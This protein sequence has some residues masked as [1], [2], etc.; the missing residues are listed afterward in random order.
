MSNRMGEVVSL[1]SSNK[2]KETKEEKSLSAAEEV[3]RSTGEAA[4]GALCPVL[5]TPGHGRNGE[6]PVQGHQEDE[7]RG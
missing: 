6:S 2:K 3:L 5:G 7:R 4:P 1:K